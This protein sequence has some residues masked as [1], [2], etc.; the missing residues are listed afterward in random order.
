MDKGPEQTNKLDH[1]WPVCDL[2]GSKIKG[3]EVTRYPC[4]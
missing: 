2:K 4:D 1:E 3:G